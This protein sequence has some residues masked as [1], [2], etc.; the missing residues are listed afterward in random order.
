MMPKYFFNLHDGVDLPD[1]YGSEHPDLASVRAEAVESIA[2]RLR[3]RLLED[4][5]ISAW[6]MNVV[7]EAGITVLILSF[8]AA[9]QIVNQ[10]MSAA[11]EP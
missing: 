7:D 6:I 5:D 11:N 1:P 8:S 3:G 10:P 2:E 9:V 4:K